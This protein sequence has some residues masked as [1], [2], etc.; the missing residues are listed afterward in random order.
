MELW[1]ILDEKAKPTGRLMDRYGRLG[2]GEYHLVVHVWIDNGHGLYLIQ[3]RSTRLVF[4]PG[5]WAPAGGSAKAGEDSLMAA[6]R[7]L[8]EELGISADPECFRFIG[9]QQRNHAFRDLWKLTLS[10]CTE[11]KLQQEEV[12]SAAWRSRGEI[13]EMVNHCEF[14]NYGTDYFEMALPEGEKDHGCCS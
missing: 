1:D 10:C 8:K 4:C 13:L 6:R 11:L 14:I 5:M 7:E 2:K 9:R 12:Q 3:R